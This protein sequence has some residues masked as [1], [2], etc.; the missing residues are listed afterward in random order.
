MAKHLGPRKVGRSEVALIYRALID[1]AGGYRR[2][3]LAVLL[4]PDSGGD[5]VKTGSERRFHERLARTADPGLA[6]LLAGVQAYE[7]F[8]RWLEDAFEHCRHEM[9]LTHGKTPPS[10]LARR[11]A[12]QLAAERATDD[13]V[14]AYRALQPLGLAPRFEQQFGAF[15]ERLAPEA[16]VVRLLEHHA[17]VQR[18]K[19]PN[20]KAPWVERFGD[21]SYVVRP[22]YRLDEVN[23][24]SG[25]YLHAYRTRPLWSFALELGLVV[26]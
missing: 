17:A 22:P 9:T 25:A 6:E 21:G 1:A 16:W 12:V 18:A 11:A 3:L 20:G 24:L 2:A 14:R 4:A 19:P 13:H 5:W 10:L 7:R 23:E 26:P 8:C 15:A